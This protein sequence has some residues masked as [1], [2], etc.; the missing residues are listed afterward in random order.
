MKIGFTAEG[1]RLQ[2]KSHVI[3]F[4][5]DVKMSLCIFTECASALKRIWYRVF[6]SRLYMTVFFTKTFQSFVRFR[7]AWTAVIVLKFAVKANLH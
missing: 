1:D 2:P 4:N 6:S 3:W 7:I 5:V